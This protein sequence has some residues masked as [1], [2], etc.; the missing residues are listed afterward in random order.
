MVSESNRSAIDE[1]LQQEQR[2]RNAAQSAAS[3]DLR[4]NHLIDAERYASRAWSLEEGYD[5][6]F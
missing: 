6:D 2:A 4:G 1:M 3:E 5:A